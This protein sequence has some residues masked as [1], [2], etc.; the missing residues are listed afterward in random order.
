MEC[1]AAV[2]TSSQIDIEIDEMMNVLSF[3]SIRSSVHFGLCTHFMSASYKLVVLRVY[4]VVAV[5]SSSSEQQLRLTVL[6]GRS[7]CPGRG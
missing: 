4:L 5:S 1:R 2:V 3:C 7:L 6:F